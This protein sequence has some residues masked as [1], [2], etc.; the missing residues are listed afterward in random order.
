MTLNGLNNIA[1]ALGSSQRM[2][3]VFVGHGNP[4]NAIEDN[5]FASG[6]REV[7]KELPKPKAILCVSAHWETRGTF[8]TAMEKPKTI[9]DF[10][11]FPPELFAVD[12]PARGS[13]DLAEQTKA[14]VKQAIV[15][16]DN[17]W[18]LDHGCW[19]VVRRMYPNA[20]V[21]VLQL[22]LDRY[23]SPDRHYNLAKDMASLR[24]NGVL[25]IGSGN[26]VHNLRMIN[27]Q[28]PNSAYDWAQEM[29][30]RFK[31]YILNGNHKSLISYPSLGKAA[32]LSVP[33]PEHFLPMLYVLGLKEKDE[34]ITIFNDKTVMGSISMTSFR[35]S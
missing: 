11:G 4:M 21:P 31:E 6:W 35:I 26:M 20:D 27:W 29:N 32:A 24:R 14:M 8:V 10:Y 16:L 9:H 15:E 22:S 23:Q 17:N 2:P 30:V 18:G 33:T 7:G 5:E 19:S 13:P 1:D 28:D 25:I 34:N 12:Y 3:L